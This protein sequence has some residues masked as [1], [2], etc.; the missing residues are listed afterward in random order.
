MMLDGLKQ[1]VWVVVVS[2]TKMGQKK[3]VHGVL[4]GVPKAAVPP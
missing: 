3:I 4:M 1:R 2:V